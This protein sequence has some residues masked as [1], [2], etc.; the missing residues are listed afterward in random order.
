M[1]M[2]PKI[3]FNDEINSTFEEGVAN[4]FG[5]FDPALIARSPPRRKLPIRWTASKRPWT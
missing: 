4:E 5:F 2:D 3:R 1:V